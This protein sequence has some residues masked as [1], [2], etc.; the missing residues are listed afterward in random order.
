MRKLNPSDEEK[1]L[2]GRNVKNTTGHEGWSPAGC[3]FSMSGVEVAPGV[4]SQSSRRASSLGW[5]ALYRRA[6]TGL[7]G[8]D[9]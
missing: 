8:L 7:C 6:V 4:K 3:I 1:H 2:G 5:R 9:V